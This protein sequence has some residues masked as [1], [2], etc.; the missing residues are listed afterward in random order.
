MQ[1]GE[2]ERRTHGSCRAGTTTLFAALEIATGQV[3]GRMGRSRGGQLGPRTSP[4]IGFRPSGRA[5]CFGAIGRVL[6]MVHDSSS[7]RSPSR[8][9]N[10]SAHP[11]H[12]RPAT[13]SNYFRRAALARPPRGR[14]VN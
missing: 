2:A 4:A 12:S 11:P 5:T 6:P 8:S 13:L 14:T 7:S 3:T 1:P 9:P 10:G